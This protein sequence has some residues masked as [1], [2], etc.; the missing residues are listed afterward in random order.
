MGRASVSQVEAVIVEI[1]VVLGRSTLPM[2]QLL[3]MGRGAVI[4]LDTAVNDEVWILANNHPI[5]RGEIQINDEKIS[6]AVTRA[7]NVYDFMAGGQST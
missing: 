7:A 1:Q 2:Q 4:P 5:A 3:R 6:I